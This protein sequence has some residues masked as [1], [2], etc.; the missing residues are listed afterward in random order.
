MEQ[1]EENQ[2]RGG[3]WGRLMGC[4]LSSA[5]FTFSTLWNRPAGACASPSFFTAKDAGVAGFSTARGHC[6]TSAKVDQAAGWGSADV[7][8]TA[9]SVGVWLPDGHHLQLGPMTLWGAASCS[10]VSVVRSERTSTT[11]W[12]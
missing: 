3:A 12:R 11:N 4:G 5:A 2:A 6:R 9:E 8:K 1:M 7:S 10:D